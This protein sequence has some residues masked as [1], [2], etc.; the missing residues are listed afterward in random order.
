MPPYNIH[1]G[2]S[3]G[4]YGTPVSSTN[5][6]AP[7]HP[8][9]NNQGGGGG[10]GGG[11]NDPIT[12]TSTPEMQTGFG[13]WFG[14]N[15]ASTGSSGV[16]QDT[17]QNAI[18]E[19]TQ[20]YNSGQ[21]INQDPNSIHYGQPMALTGDIKNNLIQGIMENFYP[22]LP[23]MSQEEF[24]TASGIDINNPNEMNSVAAQE[25]LLDYDISNMYTGYNETG[26]GNLMGIPPG[27]VG[28]DQLNYNTGVG[29]GGGG[30]GGGGYDGGGG[31]SGGSGDSGGGYG[32][33]LPG[34]GLPQVYKRGVPDPGDL[35]ERVNQAYLSGGRGFSRGGIVS[36]LRL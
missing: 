19:A 12:P 18:N 17:I 29:G 25:A 10:M 31:G 23:Q 7:N 26:T 35:Q 22:D 6:N 34:A 21:V 36:L 4:G 5:T 15:S 14:A 30:G 28:I 8:S 20:A 16:V 2:A 11:M 33:N 1:G 9:N 32:Y 27:Q 3:Y 13:S 24:F